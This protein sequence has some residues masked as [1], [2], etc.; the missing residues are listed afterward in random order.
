MQIAKGSADFLRKNLVEAVADLR[1]ERIRTEFL[2]AN[3]K[4]AAA[5]TDYAAWL[6]REKLPKATDDFALGP[7]KFARMLKE[8]ELV[9]LPVNKILEI[10]M[11][12]LRKEQK[13]FVDA[14]RRIDTEKTPKEIFKQMQS[15]HP[16]PES[17]LT[18]I[19]KDLES[20]R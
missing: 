15:E 1:D 13:A 20:I 7:E 11:D 4:A 16:T 8:T 6:E 19:N 10:G 5:L 3:R 14:A 18:D 9:D 17:L 12:Q 2:E